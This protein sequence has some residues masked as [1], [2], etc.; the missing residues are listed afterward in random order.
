MIDRKFHRLVFAFFMALIMSCVMSCVIT[1]SNV[2]PVSNFVSIWMGAWGFGFLIAFP[3]VILISPLVHKLTALVLKE[4][5]GA[6]NMEIRAEIYDPQAEYF[7]EEGCF[8]TELSNS[9]TDPE[10]SVARARV[11]P[12]KITKWHA[13]EGISERY[14]IL[15]GRGRAEVGESDS[16]LLEKGDVLVIPANTRQRIN[17][18]GSEDLIFLAICS[19]RFT[20]SAYRQLED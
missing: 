12:G 6:N 2:G 16:Q 19:P 18:T 9:E 17:N 15:E 5:Q 1:F 13:L 3:S 8:I 14:L 4:E 11:E 20:K 7:F 10:V